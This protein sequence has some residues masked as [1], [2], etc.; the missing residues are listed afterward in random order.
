MFPI[1]KMGG[2]CWALAGPLFIAPSSWVIPGLPL[3]SVSANPSSPQ[4]STKRTFF[5]LLRG[6]PAG[7]RNI[8]GTSSIEILDCFTLHSS[9]GP[10]SINMKI[11][12]LHGLNMKILEKLQLEGKYFLI[13]PRH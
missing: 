4:F 1:V 9:R 11:A 10:I 13:A 8:G 12:F 7:R 6:E 2:S 3:T 5:L